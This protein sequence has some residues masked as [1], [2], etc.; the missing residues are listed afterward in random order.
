MDHPGVCCDSCD[1]WYHQECKGMSDCVYNGLKNIRWECFKCGVQKL[2]TDIFDITIFED[3]N[4]FS[5]LSNCNICCPERDT[6]FTFPYATSSQTRPTQERQ[7]PTKKALPLR[8]V[9]LNC[10]SIKASGKPA[11]LKNI[12]SSLQADIIMGNESWLN[13]SMPLKIVTS[14]NNL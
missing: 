5:P 4:F 7:T 9:L 10:Q 2:S 13:P 11:Q 14:N 12:V 8:I 6:S 1:A 3:S